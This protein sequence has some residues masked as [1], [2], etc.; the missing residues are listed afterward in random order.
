MRA[1][2]RTFYGLVKRQPRLRNWAIRWVCW[3]FGRKVTRIENHGQR[4]DKWLD[5]MEAR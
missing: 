2:L 3:K 1:P 5:Q 4:L